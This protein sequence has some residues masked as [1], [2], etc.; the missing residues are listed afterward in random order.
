MSPAKKRP[1]KT[2]V[3]ILGSPLSKAVEDAVRVLYNSYP[4]V[5]VTGRHQDCDPIEE[6]VDFFLHAKVQDADIV[7]YDRTPMVKVNMRYQGK[8]HKINKANPFSHILGIFTGGSPLTEAIAKTVL[9]ILPQ[10]QVAMQLADIE[11]MAA[12]ALQDEKKLAPIRERLNA[13]R[14]ADKERLLARIREVF[15]DHDDLLSE[16][17]ILQLWRETFAREIME[18]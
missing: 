17:E 18:S 4:G 7:M 2:L 3:A 13:K 16:D 5:P 10:D 8:S 9:P 14:T 11:N 12:A 6:A 15:K 1:Q